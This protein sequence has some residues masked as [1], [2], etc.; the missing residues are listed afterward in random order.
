MNP[1]AADTSI[2]LTRH[3]TQT[4]EHRVLIHNVSHS[5]L[6]VALGCDPQEWAGANEKLPCPGVERGMLGRPQ[7]AKFRP[8]SELILGQLA[9]IQAVGKAAIVPYSL[10]CKTGDKTVSENVPAWVCCLRK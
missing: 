3:I 5:D 6:L 1:A 7:Y 2:P 10:K 4:E 8:I 9:K